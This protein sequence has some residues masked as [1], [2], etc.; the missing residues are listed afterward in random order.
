[1]WGVRAE[2]QEEDPAE[3]EGLQC[4]VGVNGVWGRVESRP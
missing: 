3:V 1:M 2:H 4:D